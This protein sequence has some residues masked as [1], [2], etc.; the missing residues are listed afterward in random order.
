MHTNPNQTAA[1]EP[2]HHRA[3][4]STETRRAQ[5]KSARPVK[6]KTCPGCGRRK[7]ATAFPKL[8][9]G[10]PFREKIRCRNCE[11]HGGAAL[12][13]ELQRQARAAANPG[14]KFCTK[15]DAL[16]PHRHSLLDARSN[17]GRATICIACRRIESK[18]RRAAER[19][20][21]RSAAA[22]RRDERISLGI[23]L[24]HATS[25]PRHR[26]SRAD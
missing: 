20:P 2:V 11:R 26:S 6:M 21:Q 3:A 16:K 10:E 7:A 24:A 5:T 25:P 12:R 23:A 15:C 9:P 14:H 4:A 19:E 22:I 13:R 18:A 17:D 1:A 8:K